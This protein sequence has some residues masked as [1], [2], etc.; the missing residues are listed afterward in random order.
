MIRSEQRE[1]ERE[2]ARESERDGRKRG[3][4]GSIVV[5]KMLQPEEFKKTNDKL[6]KNESKSIE[7]T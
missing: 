1:R 3:R 2:R 6:T 7:P 5:K 4:E